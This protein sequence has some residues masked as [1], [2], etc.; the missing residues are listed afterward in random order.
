MQWYKECKNLI[1]KWKDILKIFNCRVT[2]LIRFLFQYCFDSF[3][4]WLQ[5]FIYWIQQIFDTLFTSSII[6]KKDTINKELLRRRANKQR[7]I[8][9]LKYALNLAHHLCRIL[10]GLSL[11]FHA[12]SLSLETIRYCRCYTTHWNSIFFYF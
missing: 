5:Y 1:S 6:I 3:F 7:L 10:F 12:S 4:S 8:N 9:D 11:K 2:F